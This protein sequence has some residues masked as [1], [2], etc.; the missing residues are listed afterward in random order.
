MSGRS[1][2]SGGAIAGSGARSIGPGTRRGG[3]VDHVRVGRNG[4][5][6][7]GGG[8]FLPSAR[9][10]ATRYTNLNGSFHSTSS[11]GLSTPFHSHEL[12]GSGILRNGL[13]SA[14]GTL[15]FGSSTLRE[16]REES[17]GVVGA[18]N[19]KY[20]SSGEFGLVGKSVHVQPS[21]TLAKRVGRRISRIFVGKRSSSQGH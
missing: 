17:F 2:A 10:P 4:L 3:S 9:S 5:L 15:T 21:P 18:D 1:A 20:G 8:T 13:N 7:G 16:G 11:S 19:E 14:S 12:N 6:T